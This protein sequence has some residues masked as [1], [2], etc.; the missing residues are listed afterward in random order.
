LK[1]DIKKLGSFGELV[2]VKDG[3]ARNYLLPKG[4]VWP[5]SKGYR[6]K[7]DELKHKIEVRKEQ[8]KE[9]ALELAEKLKDI[10]V[11]IEV[12]VGEDDRLFGSVTNI[13][14]AQKLKDEGVDIDKKII[15]IDD[16]IKKLG[17]YKVSINLH[18]EAEAVCKVWVVGKEESN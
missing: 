17:V 18:P 13:D 14:I 1:E 8:E 4:L 12:E 6:S 15:V 7:I 2:D 3:Y 9:A 5:D 11:T 10:S 16:P